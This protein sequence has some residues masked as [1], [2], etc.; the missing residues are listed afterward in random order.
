MSV[1]PPS[2]QRTRLRSMG[3]QVAVWD[4]RDKYDQAVVELE[5]LSD[6]AALEPIHDAL[7]TLADSGLQPADFP[8]ISRVDRDQDGSVTRLFLHGLRGQP[9][10]ADWAQTA[11]ELELLRLAHRHFALLAQLHRAGYSGLRPTVDE[12]FWNSN[13]MALTVFGWEDVRAGESGQDGDLRAAALLWG[14]ALTGRPLP[15]EQPLTLY[16]DWDA[17]HRLSLRTR[18]MLLDL[19]AP[20]FFNWSDRYRIPDRLRADL[21]RHAP[22]PEQKPAPPAP[23]SSARLMADAIEDWIKHFYATPGEL[24]DRA[25]LIKDTPEADELFDLADI[26]SQGKAED[27]ANRRLPQQTRAINRLER[28]LKDAKVLFD[29]EDFFEAAAA[30]QKVGSARIAPGP[31]RLEAWRW[32]AAAEA[33]Q[34]LQETQDQLEDTLVNLRE[35]LTTVVQRVSVGDYKSANNKLSVLLQASNSL[36]ELNALRT[37]ELDID[38]C[39]YLAGGR[40]QLQR[41]GAIALHQ[42]GQA[43]D[44]LSRLHPPAYAEALVATLGDPAIG[45]RQ[46]DERC[47]RELELEKHIA[48]S[49]TARKGEH[50]SEASRA[51]LLAAQAA[52]DLEKPDSTQLTHDARLM[53]LRQLVVEAGG[54]RKSKAYT[55]DGAEVTVSALVRLCSEYPDDQWGQE[56]AGLWKAFLETRIDRDTAPAAASQLLRLFPEDEGVRRELNAAADRAIERWASALEQHRS[57]DQWVTPR[58][59]VNAIGDLRQVRHKIDEARRW[60]AE[61]Q[62]GVPSRQIT[63]RCNEYLSVWMGRQHAQQELR[64]AYKEA[65]RLGQPYDH[66]LEKAEASHLELFDTPKQSI[67]ALRNTVDRLPNTGKQSQVTSPS[68]RPARLR[69]P[70]ARMSPSLIRPSESPQLQSFVVDPA[71]EAAEAEDLDLKRAR[72]LCRLMSE[73]DIRREFEWVVKHLGERNFTGLAGRLEKLSNPAGRS[74][75]S[76]IQQACWESCKCCFERLK[77]PVIVTNLNLIHELVERC[78]SESLSPSDQKRAAVALMKLRELKYE[79]MGA[80]DR[81]WDDCLKRVPERS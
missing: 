45:R 28:C 66:L 31:L 14:E 3:Q 13:T 64:V 15:I 58:E 74:P 6:H 34:V 30:F 36:P 2:I 75:E 43:C 41:D 61:I 53:K 52:R 20:T 77:A 54:N 48:D 33:M 26:L 4:A 73:A 69:K 80:L 56:C 78:D 79:F 16:T 60:L 49:E 62:H 29:R 11:G 47:R 22:I 72:Q 70:R 18:R 23:S 37:L 7:Q 42:F 50:W 39:R 71:I 19:L 46:A 81:V 8:A 25:Q 5:A 10:S 17:W 40:Y 24:R 27:S 57:Q 32:W 55:A 44:G 21:E 38:V 1:Y 12:V 67:A 59:I 68:L 63:E 76:R 51:Y 35:R 65:I 9:L